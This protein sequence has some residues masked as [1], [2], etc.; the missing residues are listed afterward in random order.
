[1]LDHLE[2]SRAETPHIPSGKL[3]ILPNGDVTEDPVE[4]E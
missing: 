2:R 4:D 3:R 1:M